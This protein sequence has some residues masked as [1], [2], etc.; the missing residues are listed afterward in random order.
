MALRIIFAGTAEFAVPALQ[1]VQDSPHTICAVFTKPDRLAG[2]GL[3]LNTSPV[4][5]FAMEEELSIQ[6]PES[7]REAAAQQSLQQ[8]DADILVDIAYGLY[9]PAAVLEMFP[10][11]CI[12]VHPSLLPRWRGAAPIPHAILAG[13]AETGVSI[14][15]VDE[16]WDTGP[17]LQQVKVAIGAAATS[18]DLGRY[19]SRV[20]A[21]LLLE[22]L[23]AIEIGTVQAVPQ[24]E[25]GSC[26]ADKL[27][28]AGGGP[29]VGKIVRWLLS[30]KYGLLIRGLLRSVN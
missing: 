3:R 8:Y 11:G 9:L 2:R 20:G 26:Y 14:M 29:L 4:K 1:A 18:V 23:D 12:N 7:L 22:T 19:L 6:Q 16:G 15:Q 25:E 27:S 30:V 13:D 24:P 17:V 21:M 5:G 28:K 10:Y